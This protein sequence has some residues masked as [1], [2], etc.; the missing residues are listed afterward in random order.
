M[1][2][3]LERTDTDVE[4]ELI[5][6]Q[7]LGCQSKHRAKSG[8]YFGPCTVEVVAVWSATCVRGKSLN[9]CQRAV[10]WVNDLM[11]LSDR[12]CVCGRHVTECWTLLPL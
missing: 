2:D 12:H 9:V 3:V 6:D 5:F 7:V 8:E 4:L 11:M 1:P 10:D